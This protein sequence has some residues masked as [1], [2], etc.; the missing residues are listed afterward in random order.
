MSVPAHGLDMDNAV[1]YTMDVRIQMVS[2]L[3]PLDILRDLRRQPG[4]RDLGRAVLQ[5]L[6]GIMRSGQ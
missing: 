2:G 3:E 4:R 1:G 6:R 5:G